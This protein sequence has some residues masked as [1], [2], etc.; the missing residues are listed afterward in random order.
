[1]LQHPEQRA[2]LRDGRAG[3]GQ[4]GL[5]EL[6]ALLSITTP[7]AP[8]GHRGVELAGGHDA[9]GE[10]IIAA[11]DAA[12]RDPAEFATPT[13][14]TCTGRATIQRGVRLRR[15]TPVLA[16]HMARWSFRCLPAL[17][18]RFPACG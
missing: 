3:R 11:G 12:N 15:C 8:G 5:E 1:M 7:A 17:L 13:S 18:R 14:S 6:P 9:G 2:Q 4:R 16:S 10:G